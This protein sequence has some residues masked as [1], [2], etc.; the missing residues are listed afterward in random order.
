MTTRIK[1]ESP[2]DSI[3]DHATFFILTFHLSLILESHHSFI[4]RNLNTINLANKQIIIELIDHTD[5]L[6]LF[7]EHL[8]LLPSFLP[9]RNLLFDFIKSIVGVTFLLNGNFFYNY[10]AIKQTCME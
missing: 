1:K 8:D 6:Q 2:W 5:L 9:F 10:L 7:Q 4:P 3:N